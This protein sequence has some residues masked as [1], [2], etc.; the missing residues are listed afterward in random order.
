MVWGLTAICGAPIDVTAI[1]L[2]RWLASS[3]DA[4]QGLLHS[5]QPLTDHSP[6][7]HGRKK[8]DLW[9]KYSC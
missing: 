3:R 1:V 2:G 5:T 4:A 9:K 6:L 7:A 8:S